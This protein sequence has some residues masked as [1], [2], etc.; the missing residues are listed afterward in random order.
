MPSL[1]A[2]A[3]RHLH[4]DRVPATRAWRSGCWRRRQSASSD[5]CSSI[6]SATRCCAG[7]PR[8]PNSANTCSSSWT[9]R[10][11]R[12]RPI[13]TARSSDRRIY[14]ARPTPICRQRLHCANAVLV[15]DAAHPLLPVHEPGRERGARGRGHPRRPAGA[16]RRRRGRCCA[17]ALAGFCETRRRHIEPYIAQGRHILETFVD[18]GRGFAA[19]Y[20]DGAA[21]ELETHLSIT[22]DQLDYLFRLLDLDGDGYLDRRE[23]DDAMQL[24]RV[25]PVASREGRAVP[26]PRCGRRRP[27][28]DHRSDDHARGLR[29]SPR[30]SCRR[31][32]TARTPRRVQLLER[33]RRSLELF[34]LADRSASS[35]TSSSRISAFSPPP[36]AFTLTVDEL[37]KHFAAVDRRGD[38]RLDFREPSQTLRELRR[39]PRARAPARRCRGAQG[40]QS[41]RSEPDPL[42][43]HASVDEA[44]LRAR[45]F[46]HR[47]AEQPKGVIPL[48]AAD[49]D[50]PVAE[51]ITD[52]IGT[53]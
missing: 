35:A 10:P 26:G 16:G 42:F 20:V 18:Y 49:P 7:M 36:K 2:R 8:R 31:C 1:A 9:A 3:R 48:T 39:R 46:N 25:R 47:W 27:A 22:D 40:P 44:T 45:A 32:A 17:D 51:E 53:T 5:F 30:R 6:P 15:G 19:P 4:Q 43:A 11:S 52:A 23:F 21:S 41:K 28:Q 50:F 24:L 38:G 12:C 29:R 13:S 37:K 34:R 33:H 14:G